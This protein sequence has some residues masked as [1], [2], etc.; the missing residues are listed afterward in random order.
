M[1]KLT[2]SFY[3][4]L[5]FTCEKV[6]KTNVK[7]FSQLNCKRKTCGT[8]CTDVPLI[9]Q[10]HLSLQSRKHSHN[11]KRLK[12]KI[13]SL[14]TSEYK[15]EDKMSDHEVPT[16]NHTSHGGEFEVHEVD[17]VD[18][19]RRENCEAESSNE[20]QVPVPIPEDFRVWENVGKSFDTKK[21]TNGFK[22]K[23]LS[24]NLLAQYLLECHPYLYTKCLSQDLKWKARASRLFDEITG[25]EP[26][27][28]CFQE[29]QLS[30]LD[31]FFSKFEEMGYHGIFKQKTG[32]RHD[33]CAIYF[34]KTL[35]DLVAHVSVEYYQPDLPILNRDNVG[36]I[37]KLTPRGLPDCPLVVATTHLLYNPKRTD[38]R[39]A[40]MQLLLAE[41]D[42]F[43]YHQIGEEYGHM[44]IILAGD[45]NST[46]ESPV[47]D[48]LDKGSVGVTA[49]R[50]GSDWKR[51]GVT[52]NCQHLA[53]VLDRL[54][55]R[56]TEFASTQIF[57]SDYRKENEPRGS[58]SLQVAAENY[59][60]MFNSP[61]VG[62]S[63]KLST[64]YKPF[65]DGEYTATTYQD[66]WVT[67]DYIFYNACKALRLVDRLRLP[68]RSECEAMGR[69]PNHVY[70]SDHLALAALFELNIYKCGN[71][72]RYYV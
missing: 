12:I 68:T 61:V 38:V 15:K 14:N 31:T 29:V 22:F 52:D 9:A 34:K 54:E 27:I 18:E 3:R 8:G 72:W 69:L 4:Y 47:I 60:G 39:L 57:N 45:F 17:P 43:A 20:N 30:H 58:P 49:L 6:S 65:R 24:Y 19:W 42:R 55:K 26:D 50:D 56:H 21:G 5:A 16:F 37:V 35:F 33:G 28:L 66:A 67:V 41:I 70:G 51:I 11:K 7:S 53:V 25:L 46:P 40:Q 44:P 48:L 59:N 2:N 63:L 62:Q 32:H 23:V 10:I 1:L 64:V 71:S 36:L 13:P